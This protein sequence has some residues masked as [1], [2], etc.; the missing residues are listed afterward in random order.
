MEA[1]EAAADQFAESIRVE[2][3]VVIEAA[4]AGSADVEQDILADLED[5][6]LTPRTVKVGAE[7]MGG[8]TWQE[9]TSAEVG[10]EDRRG[11]ERNLPLAFIVGLGLAAL[12]VLAMALGRGPFAAAAPRTS[13][14]E[15]GRRARPARARRAGPRPAR[16]PR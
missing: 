13:R 7:G 15:A 12:A 16:A 9:P 4:P 3:E 1:V 5:P 2:E 6:A 8:P 14:R 11:G 10:A